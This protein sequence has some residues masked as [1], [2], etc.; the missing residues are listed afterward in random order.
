MIKRRKR[1]RLGEVVITDLNIVILSI[2]LVL[3]FPKWFM[4]I[5]AFLGIKFFID[6]IKRFK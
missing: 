1:K 2:L 6:Y 4:V 3:F 5:L